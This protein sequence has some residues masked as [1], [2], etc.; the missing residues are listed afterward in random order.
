MQHV[1]VAPILMTRT[2]MP[3]VVEVL[4]LASTHI[5]NLLSMLSLSQTSVEHMRL[6]G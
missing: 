3:M 4:S 5:L 1:R 6:I 2:T